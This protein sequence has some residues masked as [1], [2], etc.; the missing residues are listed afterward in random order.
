[1]DVELYCFFNLDARW[2]GW[3]KPRTGYFTPGKDLVHIV[4]EAGGPTEPAW[5][6]AENL[7]PPPGAYP[8]TGQPGASRIIF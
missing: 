1:V 3:S 2:G 6:G 4:Q 8:W 7:T 5:M